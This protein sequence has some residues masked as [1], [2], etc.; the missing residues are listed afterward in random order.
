M[1]G[2]SGIELHD[3][4]LQE[5]PEIIPR[6]VFITGDVVSSDVADF[7]RKANRPVLEKPF[8]LSELDAM[9]ERLSAPP[10]ETG[11]D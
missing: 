5:R 10:R 1:P 9:I 3:Q 11:L 6:L 8:E 4:I 7:L 2:M